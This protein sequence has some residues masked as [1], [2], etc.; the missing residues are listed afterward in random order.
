MDGD[1]FEDDIVGRFRQFLRAAFGEQH[2]EENLRFVTQ[3]LS[4]KNLREYF[5]KSFYKDHVKRYKK[6]PIL[7]AVLQPER[8]VQRAHL[9]APLHTI[10]RVDCSQRVPA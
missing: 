5:V 1:W 2:F 9:H 7:L 6:R 3:S 10:D 4:V 8:V